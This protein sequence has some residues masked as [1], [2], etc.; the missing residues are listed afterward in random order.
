VSGSCL[1]AWVLDLSWPPADVSPNAHHGHWGQ[2]YRAQQSYK[3][4]CAWEIKAC[5][6]PRLPAGSIPEIHTVFFQPDNGRKRD[7]DNMI[8]SSKY[9]LD[10]IAE[11]LGVNDNKF[12]LSFEFD[13]PPEKDGRLHLEIFVW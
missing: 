5:K 10:A 13:V 6:L 11:A 9:A 8:A 12:R 2:R 1:L 3:T 7:W 4:T